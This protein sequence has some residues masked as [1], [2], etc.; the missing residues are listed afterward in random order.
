M[1]PLSRG[2]KIDLAPPRL[3]CSGVLASYAKE[4]QLGHVSEI[5]SDTA[6][7]RTTVLSDFVPDDIWFVGKTPGFHHGK[8]IRK[9]GVR[10][11]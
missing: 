6:A 10:T 5:K 2:E 7:I 3:Q 4:K 1:F 11:P 9:K 8:R